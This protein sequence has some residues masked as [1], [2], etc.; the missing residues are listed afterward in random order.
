MEA[1]EEVAFRFEQR[2]EEIRAM[3]GQTKSPEVRQL[4]IKLAADYEILVETLK[5]IGR[6]ERR[7]RETTQL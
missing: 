1:N 2:A 6:T 7:V 5:R 3:A 4:L